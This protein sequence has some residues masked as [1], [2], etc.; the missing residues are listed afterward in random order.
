MYPSQAISESGP[1]P[2]TYIHPD[3]LKERGKNGIFQKK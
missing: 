2:D 1:E 3:G